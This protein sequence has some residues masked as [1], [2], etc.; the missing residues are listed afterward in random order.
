[1][2]KNIVILGSSGSIGLQTIDVVKRYPE[3]F[4][5]VGLAV[6]KSID[7][8][9]QQI[10][11]LRPKAVVVVDA[12]KAQELSRRIAGTS[13]IPELLTSIE[14]L[15]QLAAHPEA[16]LV[17]NALVGS[18]GLRPTLA[19]L[20]AGKTLAL[21]NKES[22]V[23]GGA[24]VAKVREETGAEIL[25]VDSEHNAIFQCMVG[26]RKRE[27]KRL[28][29]TAS[30]GP[31]RGRTFSELESVTVEEALKHPR[32]TMGPKITIDSATLMN[33][34][35]EVIEAHWLF[36]LPYEQIDVIVH[37]QSI[38]HSMVEFEDGSIKAHLGQT[39][40]RIPIQY[41]LSYP[42]RLPAPLPSLDFVEVGKLTFE[43]PDVRNFPCLA[44][45]YEAIRLGKTYPAVLNATNEQAVAAFLSKKIRFTDIP[46]IIKQ[47]IERHEP[48]D[49]TDLGIVLETEHRAR[50]YADRLITSLIL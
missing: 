16:D 39:D 42:D 12:E 2:L 10:K 4:N 40:M 29:V 23:A 21:A 3:L 35:L 48:G 13:N 8:L 22:M 27:I 18:V 24:I 33:K 5:V 45:A 7:A 41:T 38:I 49:E 37:P 30:G 36:D 25:P 20:R 15:E 11:E 43:K 9:E 1:M 32:W 26:E 50:E 47:V 28:I 17:L 44:Y 14:G 6:N 34:G 31:F 19:A 46:N